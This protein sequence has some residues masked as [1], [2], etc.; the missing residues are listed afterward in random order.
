MYVI[1]FDIDNVL[2]IWSI[3]Q[4]VFLEKDKGVLKWLLCVLQTSD[5]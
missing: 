4:E 1:L 3:G 2:D 5:K